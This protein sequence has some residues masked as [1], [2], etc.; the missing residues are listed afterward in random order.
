MRILFAILDWGLGHAT[1]SMVLIDRWRSEGKNIFLASSGK[2]GELLRRQYPELPYLNLPPYGVSYSHLP[3]QAL[4]VLSQGAKI[5]K[6]IRSEAAYI[7][8]YQNRYNFDLIISDHRYGCSHPDTPSIFLSHQLALIPP[9]LLRWSR[10]AIF[11]LHMRQLEAF[12]QIWIPDDEGEEN[13]SGSLSHAYSLPSKAK[14]IGPLSRFEGMGVEKDRGPEVLAILSGPEPQRSLLEVRLRDELSQGSET[15][16]LVLGKPEMKEGWT[17]GKLRIYPHLD[18]FSLARAMTEA[19]L[20]I[21]RSGYSSIMDY[22][23]LGLERVVLIPTPGQ[24]EQEYLAR[25]LEEKGYAFRISQRNFSLD[26]C[27]KGVKGKMG[28]GKRTKNERIEHLLE[29]WS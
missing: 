3:L 11:T 19:D 20:V 29:D 2:A 6:V 16:C 14:F 23:F 17:E 4:A 25:H 10:R 21:S 8:E 7:R 5:R 12:D 27:L 28:F 24:S 9:P 18:S 26:R 15:A 22:A 13:L 1:R